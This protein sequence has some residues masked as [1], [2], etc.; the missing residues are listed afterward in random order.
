MKIKIL[1]VICLL[2]PLIACCVTQQQPSGKLK[3]VATFYPLYN[4][5]EN[6]GGERV[7]V[8]SLIPQGIEPHEFE[9]SPA[10]IRQL[11]EADIFIYNGAGMEP[12]VPQLLKGTDST[13]LLSVD[14]SKRVELI[15]SQDPDKPGTDPHIWLDPLNAERQ[16]AA[17]RDAFIQADPADKEYY[18]KN[19]AAYISKLSVLDTKFRSLMSTCKKK[20]IL[21]AHATLAYFCKEYGCTQ[22]AIT[23]INPEA[24]PSPADLVAIIRQAKERNVTAVFFESFINPKSAQLI[25]EEI[26]GSVVA[27]NSVHGLTPEEQQRG[28]NYLSLMERNVENIKKG[29]ECN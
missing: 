1:F 20:D 21:I 5:A 26:N 11:N 18:D 29:L 19:T 24:E 6:V 28:E 12:W 7:V 23:G 25:A 4:F 22:I 27:F 16:V 8:T 9:P 2:V 3:V 14:T 10:T 17:I 13:K 15:S